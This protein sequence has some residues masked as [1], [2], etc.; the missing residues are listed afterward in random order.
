MKQ[1][2]TASDKL[3]LIKKYKLDK[4]KLLAFYRLI[5]LSRRLDDAEINMKKQSKAY[6]QISSAGHEGILVAVGSLLKPA[7]DHA[8][9]YYRDRALCLS[10]GVSPYEIL[11]QANGNVGDK[12]SHGRQMPAHWGHVDLN[13]VSKSSCTGTQ[14]NQAVG[15]AESSDYLEQ[16]KKIFPKKS[17]E[18]PTS[19]KDDIVYVSTGDGTIAQGEFWE[20]LNAACVGKRR[21]LFLVEDNKLAISVPSTV[22]VSGGSI[23]RVLKDFPG[24]TVYEVNGNC[25]IESYAV[26][27]EAVKKLRNNEGPVLIQAHVTRPYSHSMSDDH[28]H[29]RPKKDLEKEKEIDVFYSYRKFLED[30]KIATSKELDGVVEAVNNEIKDA[31]QRCFATPTP[32]K[33]SWQDHLFSMSVD[34]KS[35]DFKVAGTFEG[36]NDLPMAQ[37][38]NSVLRR[39]VARNPLIR[40]FGED[41]ADATYFELLKDETLKGKGGVFKVTSGVQRAGIENQVFNSPLA[42][43]NIIGRAIGMSIRGLKPVVEIQ[44]FDYI[45]PAFMQ[46]KNEMS[47][48][49]YRSGGDY[50]CPM[51]VRVAIGGY[52]KG[53]AIYHSQCGESFFTHIPGV[54]VAYPY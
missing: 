47:T 54:Y 5:V 36:K 53:G 46:L 14:F 11:C 4:E 39:E 43:A 30:E 9:A 18:F 22:Q 40:V 33:E 48:M 37:T 42:E 1:R 21:V 10:L 51:V 29:Y 34:P 6:F 25:P 7:Y 2:P 41:V 16:L 26:A 44:F 50:K 17:G 12:A 38:I 8:L 27:Y 24:L 45:W 32:K 31:L 13:L 28:A 20:G 19:H 52:L 35:D 15:L 49:R 3:A 23:S